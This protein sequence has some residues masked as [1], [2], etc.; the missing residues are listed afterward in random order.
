MIL[1]TDWIAAAPALVP[2]PPLPRHPHDLPQAVDRLGEVG[3]GGERGDGV[4]A[5]AVGAGA[6]G[7]GVALAADDG[8]AGAGL[9]DR[10]GE[11][12]AGHPQG[13]VA[14]DPELA[15]V[16]GLAAQVVV[17]TVDRRIGPEPA[18][19]GALQGGKRGVQEETAVRL[20]VVL[21]PGGAGDDVADLAF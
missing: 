5:G 19:Q 8:G 11:P 2:R 3:L 12:A 15:A 18:A 14:G 1:P 21:G 17:G 6:V 4:G 7:V 9:V 20:G 16:V 13:T 10:D